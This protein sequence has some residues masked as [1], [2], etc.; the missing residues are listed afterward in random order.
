MIPQL[1]KCVDHFKEQILSKVDA[2]FWVAGGAL[3]DYFIHG[4]TKNCS[5]IDLYFPD[6]ENLEKVKQYLENEKYEIAFESK[7]SIK[8]KKDNIIYDLVKIFQR[9]PKSTI[10][11]FDF[12]VCCCAVDRYG[13][14]HHESFFIDLVQR[15][16]ILN[17]PQNS[18]NSLSRIRK[19]AIKGFFIDNENMFKLMKAIREEP[20]ENVPKAILDLNNDLEEDNEI[21]IRRNTNERLE[22]Q[23]NQSC[24]YDNAPELELGL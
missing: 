13:I 15:R 4:H 14:Y 22:R 17:N 3:R 12:T 6:N 21:P 18:F 20:I 1:K 16:L 11:I 8:M 2:N 19:Y 23:V 10:Y 5:D 9:D 7:N 24:S